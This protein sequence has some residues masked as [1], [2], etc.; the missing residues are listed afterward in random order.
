MQVVI[1]PV[2]VGL[3]LNTYAKSAVDKVRSFMPLV[4]MVCTALCI[5]S[6]LALNRAKIVSMEGLQLMFP[7]LAFHI[8][9]FVLGYW[10]SRVP[11]WRYFNP[12]Q[13]FSFVE[14]VSFVVT[15]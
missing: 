11:F 9:A 8:G 12:S 2:F 13:G 6:P 15:F 1:V 5:G 10:I 4:A 7:V 3:A 14:M